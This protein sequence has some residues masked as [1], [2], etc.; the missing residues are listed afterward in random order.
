MKRIWV[1]CI[2]LVIFCG[3]SNGT[4]TP[5]PEVAQESIAT[6][7][8]TLPPTPSQTPISTPRITLAES[9]ISTATDKQIIAIMDKVI[10][11]LALNITF[12]WEDDLTSREL[13]QFYIGVQVGQGLD[14]WYNKE[15][16]TY[17]VPV[18]N[19]IAVLNQYFE[20]YVFDPN[21]ALSAP[22]Y[23]KEKDAISLKAY[24]I[25]FTDY[26][27]IEHVTA[28]T[29]SFVSIEAVF[30]DSAKDGNATYPIYRTQLTIKVT[31][32][33]Y[34]YKSLEKSLVRVDLATDELLDKY[35]SFYEYVNDKDGADVLIWTDTK[36]KDFAF[37]TIKH[38][39][40]NKLHYFPG[41]TLFSIDE[42]PPEK[43]FIVKLLIPG[44][45][46]WYG[47]SLLDEKGVKRYYTIDLNG[48]GVGPH[49]FLNEFKT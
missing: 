18:K 4:T 36:I 29:D 46:S 20:K 3:G 33:G 34:Y 42:L 31:D 23:N 24:G 30:S 26:Y 10:R 1:I 37:I 49:Y 35:D 22:S 39:V 25:G 38:E 28:I 47:I 21:K 19:V 12:P 14:Q 11:L 7:T 9:F 43:P 27:K 2:C 44:T 8:I 13:F 41:D 48:R 17:Y 6:P 40:K 5:T 45:V 32:T 15:D 16:E